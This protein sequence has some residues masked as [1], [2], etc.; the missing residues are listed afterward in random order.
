MWALRFLSGP[1]A[2]QEILLQNGL[3]L[4][5]RDESCQIVIPS[6]GVSKKHA[7]IIVRDKSVRIEDLGSSNGVFADG[8]KIQ[9]KSL[10]SG[11]RA[12]LCD[13]VF[14]LVKKERPPLSVYNPYQPPGPGQ[15][16][17][18]PGQPME[19]G[20]PGFAPGGEWQPPAAP[21]KQ[22]SPL[23]NIQNAAKGYIERAVLPGVYK[24]AEV[25][26]FKFVVGFFVIGF[27]FTVIVF[28]AFPL[29]QI[30]KSSVERQSMDH[31][32]SLA[33]ALEIINKEALRSGLQSGLD[34]SYAYNRPGVE[35]AYIISAR[36]G[37][38][39]APADEAQTYPG[40][41]FIH[42]AR[43]TGQKVVKRIPLTA[44]VGASIPIMAYSA[45]KGANV[46][47]AYSVTLYDMSSVAFGGEK[48]AS[49][50][51]QN[52]FVACVIGF[53]LFFFLINLIEFPIS[54]INRQFG[55]ALKDSKALS[56]STKYLSQPLSE[57]CSHINSALNQIS[58]NQ[59][60]SRSG[61]S[62]DDPAGAAARR[63]EMSNL[64]ELVGFPALSVD[65]TEE[66]VAALN[67]S[68]TEQL[69]YGE[70]LQSPVAEI[71][72]GALRDH[73]K[74]L[75][76]QGRASPQEISFGEI[77]LSGASV[78]TTCQIVMGG[79]EPAYAIVAFMPAE[80]GAA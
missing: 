30:L 46:P 71:Q 77:A 70:I 69:G 57:L 5:G 37:R 28:S 76:D 40:I 6:Q 65:L 31:A 62:S 60:M 75:I 2:G 18:F 79:K 47:I 48:V 23:E 41:P 16:G 32:E 9:S 29:T 59:M 11:D 10:K 51:I 1:K 39:L 73:I 19:G 36:D 21:E 74:S 14:E 20:P 52:L 56:V 61:E 54:S 17:A 58:I 38:I 64:T 66:T 44:T 72:D 78:Q 53:L 50:V 34:V 3:A 35:R 45:E 22:L 24:M 26:E 67:S 68:F 12:A 63:S 33:R 42:E 4:L 55:K 25:M 7:Q 49:L 43:K 80:E 15:M 27:I 13:V 8:K